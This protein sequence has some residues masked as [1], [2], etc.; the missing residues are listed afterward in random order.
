[1]GWISGFLNLF[2]KILTHLFMSPPQFYGI[3][4]AQVEP[5]QLFFKSY[6]GESVH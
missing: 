5:R 2:Q 4:I 1:M 6:S 3:R